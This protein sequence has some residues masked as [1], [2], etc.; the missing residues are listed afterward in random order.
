MRTDAFRRHCNLA[1]F[2]LHTD[3][4]MYLKAQVKSFA[5]SAFVLSEYGEGYLG[6][7]IVILEEDRVKKYQF[8][9]G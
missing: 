7:V 8:T 4:F 3:V 1:D 9:T 6:G 5:I 2:H